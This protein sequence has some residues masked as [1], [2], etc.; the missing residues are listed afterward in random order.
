MGPETIDHQG[1]TNASVSQQL[2]ISATVFSVICPILIAVRVCGRVRLRQPLGPDDIVIMVAV[3]FSI[4][5]SI[6]MCLLAK[7]GIG[8]TN[9]E[10]EP[11][12][13][14]N[15]IKLFLA[16]QVVY[17]ITT[18]LTKISILLVYLRVFTQKIFRY[19]CW[20]LMGIIALDAAISVMITLLQCSPVDLAWNIEKEGKCIDL[21][22]FWLVNGAYSIASDVIVLILPLPMI[23]ALQLPRKTKAGLMLVFSL[24]I[25]HAGFG[26]GL[27]F[28][29]WSLVEANVAII[30][31]SMPTLKVIIGRLCTEVYAPF[32]NV[33]SKP[34]DPQRDSFPAAEKPQPFIEAPRRIYSPENLREA[35]DRVIH[36]NDTEDGRDPTIKGSAPGGRTNLSL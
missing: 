22:T 6:A 4:A 29:L 2:T 21:M 11:H 17:K 31:A 35:L 20:V 8:K 9:A 34:S 14:K 12:I 32:H 5:L 10:M 27:A 18:A 15:V 24:G 23:H 30:C 19:I 26:K 7:W 13:L 25:F 1:E 28:S 33:G 3:C 16:S 36:L